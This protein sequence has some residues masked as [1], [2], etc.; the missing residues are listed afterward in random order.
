MDHSDRFIQSHDRATNS[1]IVF[2]ALILILSIYL[3]QRA[4]T[5]L[6]NVGPIVLAWSYGTQVHLLGLR[7][8][9]VT[10]T[11]AWPIILGLFCLAFRYF[12]SNKLLL[13]SFLKT[14]W[15]AS[16]PG[17]SGAVLGRD[18]SIPA[19]GLL[20]NIMAF[21]PFSAL[22]LHYLAGISTLSLLRSEAV[23]EVMLPKELGVHW[24]QNQAWLA[25]TSLTAC[26]ALG[27]FLTILFIIA[28]I[29]LRRT[30]V[31]SSV[32][33][34]IKRSP[35]KGEN[36][37]IFQGGDSP[38]EEKTSLE[39]LRWIIFISAKKL[40]ENG[41]MTRDTQI[42]DELYDFLSDRGLPV[43]LST[44]SLEQLGASA[45]KKAIDDA[46]DQCQILI[47]VASSA[48]NLAS[49]W[50]RY[51]WDGFINDILSQVK[52]KGR[53][54]VYLDG[55][56]ISELPRPLRQTQVFY[57]GA[58]GREQLYNFISN[59]LPRNT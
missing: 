24:T 21:I 20:W 38:F 51:E 23:R 18:L 26:T 28:M 11:L 46:L 57:H 14:E 10:L 54:F 22:V 13:M 4:L 43:F 34:P 6:M 16:H 32:S 40:D 1:L 45:Y 5:D 27:I 37:L 3:F 47:A 35:D 41:H 36:D 9:Y 8:S 58:E 49:D 30:L 42:A 33:P 50:V 12:V 44:R 59:A 56:A 55:V 31:K 39:N 48:E 52:P 7:F 25:F 15:V 17:Y 29:R 19:G 53:V 2:F